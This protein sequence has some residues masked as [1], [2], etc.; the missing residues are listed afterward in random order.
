M[1]AVLRR[2]LTEWPGWRLVLAL[3]L[4]REMF[5]SNRQHALLE[6][7]R[8][9]VQYLNVE[10]RS[11]VAWITASRTGRSL[12]HPVAPAPA[13][14]SG[15][16]FRGVAVFAH[17]V[18]DETIE[19]L[20]PP[21]AWERVDPITAPDGS[22]VGWMR[23]HPNGD[24]AL[25]FDPD[26]A[27]LNLLSESY[28]AAGRGRAVKRAIMRLYYRVRPLL[29]RAVQIAFRRRFARIQARTTFP[30]WPVDSTAHDLFDL[31]LALLEDV[32]G[33]PVPWIAPWPVP[34][35]W[36]L[37]LT[38]DVEHQVGCDNIGLL[39]EIERARGFRS[40]WNF[41]PRRYVTPVET[42]RGLQG[43]G[44]EVGVHGLYHDG[45]DL[46]SRELLLER[47]P[48][49][50]EAAELWHATGFR[51]PATHRDW[52]LMQLL[53]FDYDSSYLDTDPF[54]PQGGGSCTWWPFFIGDLVEL[55]I[56]LLMDHTLFVVLRR[57]ENVWHEKVT[58]LRE[59]GGLA[60]LITHPDYFLDRARLD[61]YDRFLANLEGDPTMWRA[62]ARDVAGWWRRRAA[63]SLEHDGSS[64]RVI[65][66]GS[67]EAR[68]VYG[69]SSFKSEARSAVSER[70]S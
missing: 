29:P 38:H 25:P 17:V 40:T 27:M 22:T 19:P 45:R 7:L 60:L 11:S 59:R 42:V 55:P 31:V 16:H 21:G 47:L 15:F 63:T 3:T 66:P 48:A 54:E 30:Q 57:D 39:R 13:P 50:R 46:E 8:V 49:M 67:E 12:F 2:T 51:S 1:R 33:E 35:E 5:A 69:A 14:A 37:V 41:V 24:V 52:N 10:S 68:I 56:T 61:A 62:L 44:F 9:P 32:A 28:S 6:Q 18:D 70:R 65:G 26:A 36:A 23:R 53:P 20:L 43:D 34:Y 4:H 58:Y 64:W